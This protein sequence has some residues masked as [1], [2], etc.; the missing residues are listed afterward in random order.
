LAELH[1]AVRPQA[2]K[3]RS[4]GKLLFNLF[5]DTFIGACSC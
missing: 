5:G 3:K 2:T 4:S 1:H